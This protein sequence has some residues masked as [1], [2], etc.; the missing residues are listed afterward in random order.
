MKSIKIVSQGRNLGRI[1][2]SGNIGH[3]ILRQAV[4]ESWTRYYREGKRLKL[5]KFI[6]FHNDRSH[7][8]IEKLETEPI[9][10]D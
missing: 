4:G 3:N 6:D 5:D 2:S 7:L 10:L 1:V 8:Q 9:T